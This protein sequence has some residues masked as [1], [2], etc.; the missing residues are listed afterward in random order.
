MNAYSKDANRISVR[1]YGA[2]PYGF[3]C[4]S[5]SSLQWKTWQGHEKFFLHL[6]SCTYRTALLH[7]YIDL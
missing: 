6:L 3:G 4:D 2:K 1:K 5:N 7:C